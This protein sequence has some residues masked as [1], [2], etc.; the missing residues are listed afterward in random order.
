[1]QQ[2]AKSHL[3]LTSVHFDGCNRA[4]LLSNV[5]LVGKLAVLGKLTFFGKV[6]VLGKLTS[7]QSHRANLPS[8]AK[9]PL[10]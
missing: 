2:G 4:A 5:A 1:M 7:W 8:L 10:A 9:L 3:I 6:T